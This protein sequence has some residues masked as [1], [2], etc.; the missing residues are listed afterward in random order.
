MPKIFLKLINLNCIL[1]KNGI[2]FIP[3][4]FYFQNICKQ[5]YKNG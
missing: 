2:T 4:Y 1:D 5:A 3:F